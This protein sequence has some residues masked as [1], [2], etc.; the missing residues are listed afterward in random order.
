MLYSLNAMTS[1]DHANLYLASRWEM[2]GA[3][4]LKMTGQ[5]FENF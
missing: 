5:R 2:M 1:Y 3:T 4:N